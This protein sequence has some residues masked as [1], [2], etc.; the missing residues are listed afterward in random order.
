MLGDQAI[1]NLRAKMD[2]TANKQ[3]TKIKIVGPDVYDG[4]E[5]WIRQSTSDDLK[6]IIELTEVHRYAPK[7]EVESG[8]IEEKLKSWKKL[9]ETLNPKIK[10]DGFALGEMGL[11]GTGPGDCQLG[12]R[13]YEYGVD[14]FDYALQATRAGLKF[15]SVWGFEDSMHLQS[16]DVVTTFKDKYG[17]AA[18]TEEGRQYKVHTPTGDPNIDN[19][20]KIWGFWNE[21]GEEMAAQNSAN[22]VTGRP[23][24]VQAS[25]EKIRPWYYTW[26]MFCRYFPAGMKILETTDSGIDAVRATAG[27]LPNGV[28]SDVSIA[29]VNS[30]GKEKTID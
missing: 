15:G 30:T 24:T 9:A 7:S 4:Q 1:Q 23:N 3:I 22:N 20:I 8:L 29:V 16:T 27:L 21:L 11:A 28:K 5:A 10:Q 17:P 13:N 6:D 25:D 26:S 14:I 19:D 12:V 18:T 2:E